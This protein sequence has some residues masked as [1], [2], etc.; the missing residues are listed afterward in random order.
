MATKAVDIVVNV[1][2]VV[3]LVVNVAAVALF[4]VIGHNIL[5]CGQ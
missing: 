3:I 2:V 5:S 1:V 4:V